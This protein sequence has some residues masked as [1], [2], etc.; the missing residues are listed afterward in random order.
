MSDAH[1]CTH[2]QNMLNTNL[3]SSHHQFVQWIKHLTRSIHKITKAQNQL[4]RTHPFLLPSMYDSCNSTPAPNLISKTKI[5]K[6][7][8]MTNWQSSGSDLVCDLRLFVVDESKTVLEDLDLLRSDWGWGRGRGVLGRS[9]EWVCRKGGKI[10]TK[11][12]LGLLQNSVAAMKSFH[13]W[14]IF[15]VLTNMD[16]SPKTKRT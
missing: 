8:C 1:I 14:L 7:T 10:G 5:F 9:I 13:G 11:F 4:T 3:L 16:L 12:K 2:A 15:C 6:T